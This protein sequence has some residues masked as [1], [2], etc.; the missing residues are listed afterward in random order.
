MSSTNYKADTVIIG[1]GI[2]GIVAAL[3]LLD[4]NKKVVI[5]DRD[6]KEKF[7]GLARESFGGLFMVN[8]PTQRKRGIKD[9]PELA[10]SDWLSVAQM[11]P[12]DV[13]PRRWAEQYVNRSLEDVYS[14][15]VK[16]GV[17]FFPFVHWA[18][19]GLFTPGNSVPRFHLVW[20]IGTGLTLTMIKNLE[21]H[22]NKGN[23]QICFRHHVT[24]LIE[25][26]GAVTSCS[27]IDEET[28]KEFTAEGENLIVASGGIN[29]DLNRVRKEWDRKDFGEPPEVILNGS[30]RY[31][32]GEIHD[33][34]S[35][36]NGNVT[37][38]KN[39]WNYPSGV[40]HPEAD[41]E[42]HGLTLV[43]PKSALW[44]NYEGRRMGP[45]PL[46]TAYDTRFIVE[47]ICKQKKKFSWQIMNW[48]ILLKEL[49]VQN[50]DYNKPLRDKKAFG[51]IKSVLFG[52]PEMCRFLMDNC[53][54]FVYAD[55]LP[56]LAKKMNEKCGNQDIDPGLM[57]SEIK[58][59]DDNIARGPKFHNDEQLRRIAH[60]RQYLGDKLRT[61]KFQPIG[62]PGAKPYIAIREFIN[63]RKSL[64]GIQTDLSCRVLTKSGNPISG[65]Y[66]I[67]ECAGFGG[68]GVHGKGA[69]E[70]TFIGSCILTGRIAARTIAP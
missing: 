41:K 69:L 46:I 66:A 25:K 53:Q 3:E 67:G 26:S 47:E 54:D 29:G 57:I 33:L 51:F 60:A 30:H 55:T 21:N 7:G 61:C 11:G 31:A 35:G 63:S 45:M 10:L 64:G 1:G 43:P 52:S 68:G 24:R 58:K 15:V 48:K 34:I 5:L 42:N 59:Y 13:W 36:M 49:A 37:H 16:K 14:W 56:E 6:V 4:R 9:S 2:A 18:E 50:S 28:G 65:L 27:G 62:D 44:M 8:T 20:G 23:L 40:H 32:N 39:M 22:K 17:T 70:G 12:D 38:L 19:R